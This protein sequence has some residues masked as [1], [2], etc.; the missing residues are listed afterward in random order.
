MCCTECPHRPAQGM[1][2]GCHTLAIFRLC[3]NVCVMGKMLDW[4]RRKGADLGL[5]AQRERSDLQQ[6]SRDHRRPGNPVLRIRDEEGVSWTGTAR[7]IAW[8]RTIRARLL[9]RIAR[10]CQQTGDWHHY[11]QWRDETLATSWIEL[12]AILGRDF[13]PSVGR[14]RVTR[15]A[16]ESA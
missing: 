1:Y 9:P 13:V 10:I 3:A 15:A 8:A 16:R 6:W 14:A 5:A 4:A 12:Q 11:E 7:Q 2:C